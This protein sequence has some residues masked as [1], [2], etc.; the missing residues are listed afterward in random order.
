M[1]VEIA[2]GGTSLV[3]VSNEVPLLFLSFVVIFK[4]NSY[5]TLKEL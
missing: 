2:E 3:Q 5:L 1:E 4:R